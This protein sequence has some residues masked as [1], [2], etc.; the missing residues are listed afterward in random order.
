[1]EKVSTIISFLLITVS[2]CYAQINIV[3]NRGNFTT[4]QQ[5]AVSEEKVNWSDNNLTDDR[6]VTECFAASE[7]A[8]FL[9]SAIDIKADEIKFTDPETLPVSGNIF[10]IGSRLS[11]PLIK[12][13]DNPE[14]GKLETEQSY[15]IRS[16]REN[17]RIV[18]II[19]GADRIGALYGVYRYL[20]KL[21]VRFIGLGEKGKIFPGT[22]ADIP[23]DIDITENPSYPT[24]GFYA[25]GDRK[26]DNDFFLWMA[27]NRMNYWT[28][29]NQ[30]VFLLKKLGFKLSEGGH[31]IQGT[32]FVSDDEYP[33]NHPRFKGDENKPVDPYRVSLE[34]TGDA[35]KDGK[36]SIFEAH[37][38]W[39]GVKNGRRTKIIQEA[40][41]GINFCTSDE[42]GRKEFA[43]RVTEQ[44]IDGVWK[45]ADIFNFMSFDGGANTWCQCEKC[46]AFD[47]SYTD[48]MFLVTHDIL[49][50]LA[51]ARREG[52]L[53]R[54]VE[55]SNIAYLA[56]LDPPAKPLPADYDL[57]NSSVTFYPIRRCYV[58]PF[59]DPSCT[60]INQW[61][62]RAYQGW[63]VGEKR[64]YRGSM[65]IG[66]YY[67]VS[68]IKSLPVV[69]TKIMAADISWYWH[70]GARNFHYMHAP[71]KLWGTWTLN[72]YLLGKLLWDINADAKKIVDDYFRLYYPTTAYSTRKY[73]EELEIAT[74]NIKAFKHSVGL[75]PQRNFSVTGRLL[76]GDLFELDH[77]HYDTY[78]PLVNDDPDVTEMM[79]AMELAGKYLQRSL[80]DCSNPVE[81]QRLLE[82][83]KRFDYGYAIYK[84]LF[85][86]IR[87]SVFH[88][89][90]DKDM[91]VREFSIVEK[92]AEQLKNMVDVV[93]VSSDHANSPDGFEATGSVKMFDEFKKRYDR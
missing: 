86:L 77:M 69:F 22:R 37:P 63:T 3:V 57:I 59:A 2:I 15:R 1:M 36:L 91:A 90:G 64:N 42:N 29:E 83:Q 55:V 7:L 43:K 49:K 72:Q 4:V 60:E 6:A 85:H 93:Q 32:V 75:G 71:H 54:R 27:R 87:T 68:S 12:K 88:K 73:Y 76:Q 16:F 19:E 5:A 25:W 50:E 80:F 41:Q 56:T 26:A 33:Y 44:L 17:G 62:L 66:E 40:R 8:E 65:F 48:K 61:Q 10:V 9:P 82:D 92:Y 58:H 34:Y 14:T 74:A 53:N 52:K 45:Y 31:I 11:N 46:R 18:T 47:G 38:E 30:P 67:N 89:K 81:K 20:E 24:R 35:D 70:N 79:D 39:Y 78:H 84:Y 21:G 23:A 51:K 28:A 13:Y